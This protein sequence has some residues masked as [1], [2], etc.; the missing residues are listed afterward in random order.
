MLKLNACKNTICTVFLPFFAQVIQVYI[1]WVDSKL[2]APQRQLVGFQ[3]VTLDPMQTGTYTFTV[4]GEQMALWDDKDGF[5]IQPGKLQD[6]SDFKTHL[7]VILIIALARI[8]KVGA[9]NWVSL[10]FWAFNILRETKI[11]SIY[12]HKGTFSY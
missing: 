9:Q 6:V 1:S 8:L 2:P 5:V 10:G 3:R 4:K 12:N 11:S 7:L